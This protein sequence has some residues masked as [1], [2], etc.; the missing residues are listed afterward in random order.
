MLNILK[1]LSLVVFFGSGLVQVVDVLLKI[2][3]IVVFV[4]LLEVVVSEV[5]K[6]GLKVELVEFSDW[7]V[8]NII[9]V[10]GDIDVNY[11]QY[12]FFLENVNC[13]GGFQLK[14][15][16]LGIINNVGFYLKCYVSFVE[17]LEGVS[18]VIVNDLINGGCGL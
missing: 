18:V 12:V 3:I 1:I 16:V 5:G 2:G 4:L 17:L 10:Q 7:N 6:Q 14:L 9:F 13:E 15:F 11:F 8:F